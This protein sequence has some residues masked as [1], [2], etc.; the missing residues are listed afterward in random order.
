MQAVV[1][2]SHGQ[3][4]VDELLIGCRIEELNLRR[5]LAREVNLDLHL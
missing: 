4:L 1:H 5:D 2:G 3:R